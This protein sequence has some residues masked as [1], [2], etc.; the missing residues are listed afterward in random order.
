MTTPA[1]LIHCDDCTGI[2]SY[3]HEPNCEGIGPAADC[4]MCQPRPDEEFRHDD[5]CP[6]HGVFTRWP[7]RPTDWDSPDRAWSDPND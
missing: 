7:S 5:F 3:Y 2:I 4:R 1:D 6:S